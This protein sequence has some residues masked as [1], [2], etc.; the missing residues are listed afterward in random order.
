MAADNRPAPSSAQIRLGTYDALW[1]PVLLFMAVLFLWPLV[2]VVLLSLTDDRAVLTLA[3]YQRA[4]GTTLYAQV[5]WNSISTALVVTAC[6]LVL[7]YPVAY[8]MSSLQSRSAV[9]LLFA[10]VMVPFT[11][12]LLVKSYA[13]VVLLGQYGLVNQLLVLVHAPGAPYR[14]LYNETGVVIGMTQVLLPYMVLSLFSVMRGIEVEMLRA[15]ASLG[16]NPVQ[17][18]LRVYLPLSLPGI[19]AGSVLTFILGMG[20][21]VAPAL[22]GGPRETMIAQAIQQGIQATL[23]YHLAAALSVL[24]LLV[25]SIMY[26]GASRII[27]LDRLV[28][29]R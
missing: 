4:L 28:A 20:F 14:L 26:V 24:L 1:V 12:S 9:S 21:F 29:R 27:G 18:F 2:R 23:D 17:S 16:A 10:L 19:G 11:T 7:A 25:T 22:M 5:V 15:A 13:W 8:L 6:C 3:W